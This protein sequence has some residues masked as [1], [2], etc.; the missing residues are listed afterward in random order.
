[1]LAR[2]SPSALLKQLETEID[3]MPQQWGTMPAAQREQRVVKLSV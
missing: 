3:A 1:M 2:L